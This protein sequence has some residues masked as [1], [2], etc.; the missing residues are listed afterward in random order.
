[1]AFLADALNRLVQAMHQGEVFAQG[2]ME[3]LEGNEEVRD[4]YLGRLKH[5][6]DRP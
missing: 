4:I 1:M 5:R 2:S 3:A 6:V